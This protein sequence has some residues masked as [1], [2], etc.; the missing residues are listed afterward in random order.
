MLTYSSMI[1]SDEDK[2]KFEIIYN[3][4]KKLMLYHANKILGD[5]RDT[6]DVVH[7]C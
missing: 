5:T 2:S 6:E 1:E 7:E 3:T 4:Y